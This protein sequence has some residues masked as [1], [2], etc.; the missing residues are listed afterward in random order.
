M[1]DVTNEIPRSPCRN[2]TI[3]AKIH[4]F[5]RYVV[6]CRSS[7]ARSSL[8]WSS[9]PIIVEIDDDLDCYSMEVC[10]YLVSVR[11]KHNRAEMLNSNNYY[12]VL[13]R[14]K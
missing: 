14:T 12:V 9:G 7:K 2:A 8:S 10:C 1:E 13:R 3:F 4:G 6:Q 11:A 5:V